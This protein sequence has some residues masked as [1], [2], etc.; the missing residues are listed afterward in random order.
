M[1]LELYPIKTTGPEYFFTQKK[2]EVG[3]VYLASFFCIYQCF[4]QYTADTHTYSFIHADTSLTLFA[5][6]FQQSL[7]L[8]KQ[9]CV[10]LLFSSHGTQGSSQVPRCKHNPIWM[11]LSS[12]HYPGFAGYSSNIGIPLN[13]WVC[14]QCEQA[15]AGMTNL[16]MTLEW[17]LMILK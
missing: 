8:C 13:P 1:R 10:T 7:N 4:Y 12:V 2:T 5:N 14:H 15:G 11:T 9:S 6:L 17:N 16:G 3:F